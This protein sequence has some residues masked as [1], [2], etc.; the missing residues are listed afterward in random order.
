[1][2]PIAPYPSGPSAPTVR[3]VRRLVELVR[4]RFRRWQT[5]HRIPVALA[6]S[7]AVSVV[8]SFV[9][10]L[11][12]RAPSRAAPVERS[13]PRFA[14]PRDGASNGSP[15][16]SDA[17]NLAVRAGSVNGGSTVGAALGTGRPGA[18]RLGLAPGITTTSVFLVIH[19]A[20][21]VKQPGVHRVAAGARIDDAVRAAGG[22][23]PGANVDALNLAA[24][25]TDGSRV[26]V[27]TRG[28]TAAPVVVDPTPAPGYVT[29]GA[30]SSGGA[31]VASGP[32]DLN[33]ATAEQLDTLPGVGPATAAAI[34]EYRTQHGRLR[35]VT[36][37]LEI[38][39]IGDAKLA[40]L[41]SKV[42]V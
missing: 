41:R 29:A 21:A 30:Q 12:W 13:L 37:L 28:E 26:Y 14:P 20:G 25:L 27:P 24:P 23:T 5:E 16:S 11:A 2:P 9:A 19:V 4:Q 1:M 39:G 36:E 35:S 7:I 42:R 22:P 34:I 32:V 17:S 8:A 31:T 18:G 33:T 6:F 3:G 40:S 38:R 10:L 15:F